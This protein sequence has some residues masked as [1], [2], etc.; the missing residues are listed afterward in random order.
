MITI[1]EQ[2]GKSDLEL[3]DGTGHNADDQGSFLEE[4]LVD[5]ARWRRG[6]ERH[7]GSSSTCKS[8]EV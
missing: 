5:V 8:M 3:R 2:T 7:S 6:R 1:K 4:S